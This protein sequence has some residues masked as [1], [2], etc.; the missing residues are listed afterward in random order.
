MSSWWDSLAKSVVV[1][2]VVKFVENYAPY[3]KTVKT[4]YSVV[5]NDNA[6]TL[7][8]SLKSIHQ[9]PELLTTNYIPEVLTN[10]IYDLIFLKDV[11]KAVQYSFNIYHSNSST[12]L[13]NMRGIN[14]M[15]PLSTGTD[16]KPDSYALFHLDNSYYPPHENNDSSSSYRYSASKLN[17]ILSPVNS[18]SDTN[19][20]IEEGTLWVIV[21]GTETLHDMMA[22]MTWVLHTTNMED[23]LQIGDDFQFPVGVYTKA[24]EIFSQLLIHLDTFQ[25][26]MQLSEANT[27]IRKIT[28]ICF[29]GH[30]LG[31]SIAIALH[32]MYNSYLAKKKELYLGTANIDQDVPSETYTIGAALIFHATLPEVMS[33]CPAYQYAKNVHNII[34]QLDPVPRI[35]GAH[36]LPPYIKDSFIGPSINLLKNIVDRE[37]YRP[38][39][40]FYLMQP[41]S[42]SKP[43]ITTTATSSSGSNNNNE[44]LN[45]EIENIGILNERITFYDAILGCNAEYISHNSKFEEIVDQQFLLK[46]L[47]TFPQT[48]IDFLF[49]VVHD[50]D[51]ISAVETMQDVME[52]NI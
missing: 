30:S 51:A 4:A 12:S 5:Y 44:E 21:R 42:F 10:E 31:G 32:V 47:G 15:A 41:T 35:L 28:R 8:S 36:Q 7:L 38:Y 2:N 40:K 45:D 37:H 52:R 23:E 18:T 16:Q 9:E 50:H 25:S 43:I 13:N 24:K 3:V 19:Y 17:S 29:T 6:R 48:L 1:T 39:G 20:I 33:T 14:Q 26:Q 46:V 11:F 27:K 22:D 49:S 34:F